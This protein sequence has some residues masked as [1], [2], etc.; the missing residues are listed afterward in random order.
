MKGDLRGT[1]N[2]LPDF[3]CTGAQE[4]TV[5]GGG[6]PT[7]PFTSGLGCD[8]P[9]WWIPTLR[10]VGGHRWRRG[11]RGRRAVRFLGIYFCGSPSHRK[12]RQ[13]GRE[14][15]GKKTRGDT[16]LA[17]AGWPAVAPSTQSWRV[18]REH[19]DR[20]PRHLFVISARFHS[21]FREVL[22]V[23]AG[24][25]GFTEENTEGSSDV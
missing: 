14:G 4:K 12:S 19:L 17:E 21:P 15:V 20:N 1:P 13:G 16:V 7:G 6:L 25:P 8:F 22:L 2:G 10:Q 5:H 3:F 23:K 24:L 18:S 11:R 9:S